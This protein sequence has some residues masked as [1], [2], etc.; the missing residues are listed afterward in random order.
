MARTRPTSIPEYI[1]AAP[2]KSRPHLRAL[3]RILAE[4][5]PDAEQTIKWGTPFFVEPRFLFAFSAHKAH[6]NFAPTAAALQAFR[7]ELEGRKTTKNYLQIPYDEPVPE[8]L[9]R[10]IAQYR[11]DN[12]GDG[13]G[14][15]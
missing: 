7:A 11:M 6:C 13:D 10:R 1:R 14:F 5:A 15:W 2:E 8:D 4:V 9:V 12:L 3:H